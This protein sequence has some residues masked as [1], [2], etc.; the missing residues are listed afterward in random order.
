MEAKLLEGYHNPKSYWKGLA[1]INKKL[2]LQRTIKNIFTLGKP[3]TRSA[4]LE[5]MP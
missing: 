3:T 2:K 4:S 1:A 5:L